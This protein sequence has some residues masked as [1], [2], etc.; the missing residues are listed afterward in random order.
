M[1]ESPKVI[2]ARSTESVVDGIQH[3]PE[4]VIVDIQSQSASRSDDVNSPFSS[5]VELHES[6]S[7]DRQIYDHLSGNASENN[8]NG[9][10]LVDDA[11]D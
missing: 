11:L 6:D 4:D 3:D 7:V 9:T 10:V 2:E 8:I 1:T 5:K